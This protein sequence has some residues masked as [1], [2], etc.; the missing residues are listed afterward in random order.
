MIKSNYSYTRF[1]CSNVRYFNR[2]L[3]LKNSIYNSNNPQY[4]RKI[5]KGNLMIG[6][7]IS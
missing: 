6:N 7:V 1:L 5:K 4:K 2:S 3:V